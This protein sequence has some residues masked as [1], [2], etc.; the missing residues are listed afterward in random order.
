MALAGFA[1]VG[2]SMFA[3]RNSALVLAVALA[4]WLLV[5]CVFYLMMSLVR[6][7]KSDRK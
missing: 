2:A 6:R 1:S 3:W 7:E 5:S 4:G